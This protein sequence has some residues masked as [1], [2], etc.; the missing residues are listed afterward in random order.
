MNKRLLKSLFVAIL[1][2]MVTGCKKHTIS[3]DYSLKVGN[4][5]CSDGSV[6]DPET[7]TN[8]GRNDAVG[9]VF[10]V[11]DTLS[12][13]DKAYIVSLKNERKTI[14]CDTL[15]STGVS[16]SIEQFDGA[17]NT[18]ILQTF[19]VE[20]KV[21]APAMDIATT[22]IDGI[23][24]WH[25]PSV[26]ELTEIY[27]NK[28]I[29]YKAFDVCGGESFDKIWYWSSTEDNAGEQ[30]KHFNAYIVSLKEGRIIASH[31]F[32]SHFIRPVKVIK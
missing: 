24:S 14:W 23:S 27:K 6:M 32:D 7:Y 16:T 19:E 4:V 2:L 26:K 9:V 12:T 8:E 5:Y 25:L 20:K 3:S 13:Q 30:S 31:K 29:I 17:A 11:N 22:Y 18:A 10:W 28:T 15:I 21:D 1:I